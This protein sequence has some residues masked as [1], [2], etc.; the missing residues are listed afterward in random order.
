M[1][2]L[3]GVIWQSG[4]VLARLMCTQDIKNKKILEIG[5]GIGLSSLVLNHRH[6]DITATD[7]NPEAKI[8]LDKNVLLN[9]AKQIQFQLCDWKEESS[10]LGK[11]DLVIGSDVL[12]QGDHPK[13]L[14]S[15]INKH[16]TEDGEVIIVCPKRGYQ[17]KFN[18]EM[19]AFNF[20]HAQIR[21]LNT[22]YLEKVFNGHIHTYKRIPTFS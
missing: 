14:S 6:A 20:V 8:F 10:S 3:F 7:Y 2:P 21:P 5:C 16:T 18:R 11:F 1:W 9:E 4:E 19:E 13:L 12:Y 17:N 22:D 15:F